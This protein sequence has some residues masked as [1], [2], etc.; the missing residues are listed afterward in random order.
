MATEK[1]RNFSPDEVEKI[2]KREGISD[3]IKGDKA[4]IILS[5]C[6]TEIVIY[7]QLGSRCDFYFKFPY[8]E[9]V[10]YNCIMNFIHHASLIINK[11]LEVYDMEKLCYQPVIG[12]LNG[13]DE[14]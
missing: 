14:Y 12:H 3:W 1:K 13:I 2:L 4:R 8:E 9:K 7:K 10:D 6:G 5:I 11:E